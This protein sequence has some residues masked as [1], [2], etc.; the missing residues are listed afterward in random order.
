MLVKMLMILMV[1]GV[2]CGPDLSNWSKVNDLFIE[3]INDRV[4]PGGSI[5]VANETHTL[6][7]KNF[8]YLSY[9]YQLHDV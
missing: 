7:H 3:A 9:G 5:T 8:G 6:Y 4:F 1:T 2:F